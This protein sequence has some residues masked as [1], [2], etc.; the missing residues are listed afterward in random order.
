MYASPKLGKR[1]TLGVALK[2]IRY[3]GYRNLQVQNAVEAEKIKQKY[4]RVNFEITPFDFVLLNQ[5]DGPYIEELLKS[6]HLHNNSMIMVKDIR[7]D[8]VQEKR[9]KSLIKSNHF[10]VTV[11]LF[12]GGV[13]FLRREQE[14]EHFNIRI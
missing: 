13:L 9:W 5:V 11:D 12:Y 2:S 8:K 6:G 4:P 3:F 7:S 14:K 1:K 10:T